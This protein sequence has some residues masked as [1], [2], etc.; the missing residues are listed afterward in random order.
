MKRRSLGEVIAL[1]GLPAETLDETAPIDD[2]SFGRK[3]EL[4]RGN[5]REGIG[6]RVELIAPLHYGP[7]V[8]RISESV[9]RHPGQRRITPSANPP[10]DADWLASQCLSGIFL[11][12]GNPV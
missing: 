8:G 1:M 3:K 2:A 7:V 11:R 5:W 10:Y 9:I 4:A 12:S 6:V